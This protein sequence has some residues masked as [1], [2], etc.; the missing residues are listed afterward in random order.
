[1]SRYIHIYEL[2]ADIYLANMS[3]DADAN[4]TRIDEASYNSSLRTYALV[5]YGLIH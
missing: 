3:S 5:A 4:E 1:M 2:P